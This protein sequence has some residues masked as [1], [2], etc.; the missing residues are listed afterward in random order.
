M[1]S[2][3][4]AL[5]HAG[6]ILG[7]LLWPL[8]LLAPR[9]FY[10]GLGERFTWYAPELTAALAGSR[11]IWLHAASVG[12]VRSA[13]PLVRRMRSR[14]PDRKLLVSTVTATGNRTA[15]EALPEVDG[16]TYLPLDLPW[17]ASRSLQRL[18][19]ELIVLLETEIWPNFIRAAHRLRIPVVVLSGRLSPGCAR[20]YRRFRGLFGPVLERVSGFGMQDRE[21]AGRILGLGV[22]PGRVTVTGSLKQ[23][24]AGTGALP[25]L[26]GPRGPGRPVVVA[27]SLH[28]GEE[29]ALLD[30]LPE[31][32]RGFPALLMVLAPRHP[33]RFGEVDRLLRRR[34][35][36]YS[37]RS[38]TGG[39]PPD[40]CQVLLLDT[41][42]ELPQFYGWAD[43][44]F[45]GGS[46]VPAGGHNL[47]EPARWG[48]PV[49][50]GPH[51]SNVSETARE[52]LEQG[53]GVEVRDRDHLRRE[54]AD[55]LSDRTRAAAM[56]RR[57][58]Q[59]AHA[60]RKVVSRSLR[61]VCGQ[62]G[63]ASGLE[64]TLD[65]RGREA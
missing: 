26:F 41:L 34:S 45:V 48:K 24:E 12:E 25:D 54:V 37:K 35:L 8:G 15:R 40:D 38:R 42:G 27:G 64:E 50:F 6:L 55:L 3:Y 18:R 47:M 1:T 19:P 16:V 46:L 58:R 5:L 56:G 43:V 52:L 60:D 59:V 36:R 4:N 13:A 11:P 61:L 20:T 57:A 14:W 31:L 22:D 63:R 65:N 23:A 32:R 29:E 9:R 2:L 49:L 10:R 33:Q 51:R 62:L 21:N 30:V 39:A 28:R 44:A 53:G 7:L 17:L